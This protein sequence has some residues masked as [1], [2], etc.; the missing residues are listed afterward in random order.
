MRVSEWAKVRFGIAACCGLLSIGASSGAPLYGIYTY[1]SDTVNGTGQ[2]WNNGGSQEVLSFN[3]PLL[4][5]TGSITYPG[6]YVSSANGEVSFGANQGVL[7]AFASATATAQALGGS[8]PD[9]ASASTSFYGNWVDTIT[10]GGLPAGTEVELLLT[11]YLHAAITSDGAVSGN[12]QS[13]FELNLLSGSTGGGALAPTETIDLSSAS[14]YAVGTAIAY[15]LFGA[16]LSSR[17]PIG[18]SSG[19]E[20]GGQCRVRFLGHSGRAEHVC[21]LH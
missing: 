6:G 16:N 10:I 3:Q 11:N 7:S 20:R 15:R 13:T 1:G 19:R 2:S 5:Q 21:V 8:D 18:R 12:A 14:A 4:T 17:T 9:S